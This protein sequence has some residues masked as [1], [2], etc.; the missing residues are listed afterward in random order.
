MREVPVSLFRWH[1]E[2]TSDERLDPFFTRQP[3]TQQASLTFQVDV[4]IEKRTAFDLG[5]HPISQ[6]RR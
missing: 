5:S 2:L 4:K 3:Q 6:L 1:L